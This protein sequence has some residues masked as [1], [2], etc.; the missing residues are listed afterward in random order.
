MI[1]DALSRKAM[2]EHQKHLSKHAQI[3]EASGYLIAA[4]DQNPLVYD[5]ANCALLGVAA[6]MVYRHDLLG[7][8][9]ELAVEDRDDE[10]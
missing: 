8:L 2:L 10:I 1:Y 9:I 6:A 7:F 3:A 4:R 5:S